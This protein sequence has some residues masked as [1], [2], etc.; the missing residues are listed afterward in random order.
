MHLTRSTS[1]LFIITVTLIVIMS[2]HCQPKAIKPGISL[3]QLLGARLKT[4]QLNSNLNH[5]NDELIRTKRKGGGRGGGSRG[6]SGYKGSRRGTPYFGSSGG[7]YRASDSIKPTI[8]LMAI[9]TTAIAI[10]L[11]AI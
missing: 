2:T 6:G 3:G 5:A 7:G 4:N 1:V 9:M 11:K 8:N 10:A